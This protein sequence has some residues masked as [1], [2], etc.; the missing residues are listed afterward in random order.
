MAHRS[1]SC[2]IATVAISALSLLG[3]SDGGGGSDNKSSD[4]SVSGGASAKGGNTGTGGSGS[5]GASA[6]GGNAATGGS[7]SGGS[8]AQGGSPGSG[9]SASGGTSAQGGST[10]SGG[11]AS[12]GASAQGGSTGS[13]GSAAGGSSGSPVSNWKTRV[14]N[15]TDLK[16]DPDDEM[17][18]VRQL[19]YADWMDLEGIVVTSGCW[20]NKQDDAG[21]ALATG[22][23]NAYGEVVSNLKV[24]S[25]DFPSLEYIQKITV[26]GQKGYSMGD[27]GDGKN[28]PG[29]DMII[30]AVDKKDDPRPVWTTCW[31]GCNTIAQA[32]WDV[33]AKRTPEEVA[34]FVSKLRIYDILGQD[35]ALDW[36]A[37]T[38]PDLIAIRAQ[39]LVYSWQPSDAWV[40]ENVQSHGALGK[41]YPNK[42]WTYEGDTPAFLHLIPNGLHDPS[43]VDQGG[44]G[45]RFGPDKKG[46]QKGMKADCSCA[47]P[48]YT[49]AEGTA[50]NRWKVAIENDFAARMD[51]SVKSSLG[52]ANHPPIAILNGD[53]GKGVLEVSAAGG[54]SVELSAAGSKDPD[55][56]NTL[57]YKWWFYDEPSSFDGSVTIQNGSAEKATVSVPSGAGGKNLHIILEVVDNGT[58]SLTAYR[59]MIINVK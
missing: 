32:L 17:S 7:G 46:N 59:R 26:F 45:G 36:I 54:E 18:L 58:P 5:G 15:T 29:S 44:W 40:K 25:P 3:C 27:V 21:M 14:I 8:S 2:F 56:G 16:A 35:G 11:S 13:G 30:A 41:K 51:W 37:K 38:F 42:A 47:A 33:K 48:I 50:I 28:S 9:G 53:T 10:G 55:A 4:G 22:I 57:S 23:V 1:S 20:R 6:K 39:G 49:D 52:E 12:G 34:K 19:V 43:K 31:G 24:H